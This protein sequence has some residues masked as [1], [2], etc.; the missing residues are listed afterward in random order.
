MVLYDSSGNIL[1]ENLFYIYT[2]PDISRLAIQGSYYTELLW[3]LHV[4]V[5]LT[6]Q[7]CE[8]VLLGDRMIPRIIVAASTLRVPF[9][10]NVFQHR[11]ATAVLRYIRPAWLASWSNLDV[12]I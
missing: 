6:V 5:P 2:H 12:Y 3:L 11:V 8:G 9:K 1:V 4:G 7:G 10:L